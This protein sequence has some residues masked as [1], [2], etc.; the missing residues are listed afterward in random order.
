MDESH[1][2]RNVIAS[3]MESRISSTLTHYQDH[4]M[5]MRYYNLTESIRAPKKMRPIVPKLEETCIS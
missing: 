4:K 1:Q 3:F 2:I 5:L